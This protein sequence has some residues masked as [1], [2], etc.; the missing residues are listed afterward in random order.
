M[1]AFGRIDPRL[2]F[3]LGKPEDVRPLLDKYGSDFFHEAGFAE[4]A[5]FDIE[6]ATI[7]MAAQIKR[8]DTPF[9]LATLDD[10]VVGMVSYTLSHVFT[11][12]PIA[13][14]WMFYVMPSYRRSAIGRMLLWFALDLA[15]EDGASAFFATVAPTSIAGRS[16]CNLFRRA[17]F[18]PMGGAFSRRL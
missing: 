12:R 3:R 5:P 17:G 11:A 2:K 1:T 13:L 6:R 7:E 10:A 4:F 14:L 15:R 18:K 16:L 9:I 8:G